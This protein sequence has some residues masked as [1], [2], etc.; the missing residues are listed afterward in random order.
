MDNIFSQLIPLT[1]FMALPIPVIKA[2]RY[3]LGGRPVMHSIV[4]IFTWGITCFLV[5]GLGV[6]LK[7]FLLNLFVGIPAIAISKDY[8][9]YLQ[10]ALGLLFIGLGVKKLRGSLEQKSTPVLAQSNDIRVSSIIKATMQVELFK[11]KN[12][13]LLF[14]MTHI[15]IKSSMGVE[16]SLLASAMVAITAMIWISMPLFVYFLT[17]RDRD[18]VLE[19]LKDWLVKHS[20]ILGIFVYLS[21]GISVLSS[22]IGALIPKLFASLLQG[23]S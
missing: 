14:L 23:I 22:G 16:Q 9:G 20:E 10:I 6:L 21:I 2:T 7:S 11:L 3:L 5:L 15:L 8:A 19:L 13:L 18:K 12:A 17:G 4:M 1:A